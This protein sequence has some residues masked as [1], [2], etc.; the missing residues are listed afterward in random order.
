MLTRRSLLL[1][2]LSLYAQ[3]P[4]AA[5]ITFTRAYV[6]CP[7]DQHA[8]WALEHGR[9]PHA[10]ATAS[11][12]LWDFF[13]PTD[14]DISTKYGGD[15]FKE[16]SVHVPLA[17]TWD[18][19]LTSRSIDVLCSHVDVMPTLL[20]LAGIGI[21]REVQGRDLSGLLRGQGEIPAAVYI[22]GNLG[23][24]DEWRSLIRGY[25]KI[26][27]NMKDEIIGLYNLAN[28][29]DESDELRRDKEHRLT[30]DSMWALAQQWMTR[31]QDGRDAQGFRTRGR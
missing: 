3:I 18:G 8:Q 24:R 4:Q 19:K 30:R 14:F 7:D 29:P 1:A 25:D 12:S 26:V 15:G 28:D 16:R 13:K 10:R 5:T 20:G 11:P 6:A 2:P 31:L 22:E 21:P 9:F 23:K 27:W 17:I